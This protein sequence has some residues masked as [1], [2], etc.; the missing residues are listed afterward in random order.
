MDKKKQFRMI[1]HSQR[2]TYIFL[3][4][5]LF[6]LFYMIGVIVSDEKVFFLIIAIAFTGSIFATLFAIFHRDFAIIKM[7]DEAIYT[8]KIQIKWEEIEKI[9]LKENK[10]Y[11]SRGRGGMFKIFL[12]SMVCVYDKSGKDIRFAITKNSYNALSTYGKEKSNEVSAFLN[13]VSV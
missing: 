11:L 4:T 3:V 5:L 10:I 7:N 2:V 9:D 12:A 6:F 8:R 1:S 13:K